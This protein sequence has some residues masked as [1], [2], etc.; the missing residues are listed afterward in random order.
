MKMGEIIKFYDNSTD[1]EILFEVMDAFDLEGQRYILVADDDDD[2]AILKEVQMGDEDIAY[3]LIED[4]DEFQKIALLFLESDS[5]YK[6][7]F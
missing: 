5:G 7:E 4:N 1:E 6:L 2:A 3:E